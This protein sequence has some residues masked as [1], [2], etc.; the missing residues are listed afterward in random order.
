MERFEDISRSLEVYRNGFRFEMVYGR[1]LE[2]MP[3]LKLLIQ[4]CDSDN[5]DKK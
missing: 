4:M 2:N 1:L 5:K 3:G